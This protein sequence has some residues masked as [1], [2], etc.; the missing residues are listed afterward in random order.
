[1]PVFL[2]GL[3]GYIFP[4]NPLK[5]TLPESKK[6]VSIVETYT[7]SAIFQWEAFLEGTIVE[8][9]WKWMTA[10]QYEQ[11]RTIYLALDSVVWD[12]TSTKAYTVLVTKLEGEY[13]EAGLE[14]QAYRFEVKLELNIRSTATPT[15]RGT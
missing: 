5:V 14:D 11:L 3:N 1:M 2:Q 13:V 6:T 12:Q 10:E 15:P 9:W 8:L 7:G 4:V